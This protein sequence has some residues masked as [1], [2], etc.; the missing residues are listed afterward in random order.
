MEIDDRA[1]CHR[2]VARIVRGIELG[3]SPEWL[4][5]RLEAAGLRSINSVVDVT[6]LVMLEF[7]QPLSP[8]LK[9][10]MFEEYRKPYLYYDQVFWVD[11]IPLLS[12]TRKE[13][14]WV[15]T[16]RLVVEKLAELLMSPSM[17]EVQ[18]RLEVRSPSSASL[19]VPAKLIVAPE[20]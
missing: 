2:Y 4:R 3:P 18:T 11:Q 12:R 17:L 8:W 14:V 13:M 10:R 6:N 5:S 20:S 9:Y 15:P 1:G 19:A 16:E 7:G